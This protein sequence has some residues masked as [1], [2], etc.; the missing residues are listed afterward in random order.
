[1]LSF[2]SPA[3]RLLTA[4]RKEAP[5]IQLQ[6]ILKI[7]L[8]YIAPSAGGNLFPLI[9]LISADNRMTHVVSKLFLSQI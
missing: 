7:N 5:C 6:A 4:P 1:M 2:D 3:I 8:R 9:S